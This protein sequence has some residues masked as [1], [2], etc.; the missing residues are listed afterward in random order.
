VLFQRNLA[1]RI[2]AIE[3]GYEFLL[4]YARL[5]REHEIGTPLRE[6]LAAMEVALDGLG[7]VV[8]ESAVWPAASAGLLRAIER[9]AD[10]ARGAIALVLARESI[11]SLLVENLHASIH[12]RALVTDLFLVD[13]AGRPPAR[14]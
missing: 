5:G 13:Q 8:R 2:Q 14:R 3:E 7:E 12:L 4:E 1:Q 10:V 9:D 6:V 11:G